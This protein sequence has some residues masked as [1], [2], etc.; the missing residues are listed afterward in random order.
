MDSLRSTVAKL[1]L[2]LP[3]HHKIIV[4]TVVVI[5]TEIEIEM[6]VSPATLMDPNS[7][8]ESIGTTTIIMAEKELLSGCSPDRSR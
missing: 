8:V 5:T 3:D 7:E 4:A 2:I 1:Q 6:A